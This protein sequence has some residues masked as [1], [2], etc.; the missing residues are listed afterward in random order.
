MFQI[1]HMTSA[2]TCLQNSVLFHSLFWKM[3]QST[4][5]ILSIDNLHYHMDLLEVCGSLIPCFT[6]S[7]PFL[8][9]NVIKFVIFFT[10]TSTFTNFIGE[11]V[12]S[13]IL[14]WI[15]S[16]MDSSMKF[17]NENDQP[18]PRIRVTCDT[19]N[20]ELLSK[21]KFG[22]YV[23]IIFSHIYTKHFY[24]RNVCKHIV[25][26]VCVLVDSSKLNLYTKNIH[27]ILHIIC[28]MRMSGNG[29]QTKI[30]SFCV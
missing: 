30:K 9:E 13:S 4:R 11:Y 10:T 6:R 12:H 18:T 24:S 26:D 3:A 27:T 17:T 8:Y 15:Y 28:F 29:K 14:W 16:I 25:A 20:S 21:I 19:A 2:G 22:C 23:W 7:Q 1:Y 5:T